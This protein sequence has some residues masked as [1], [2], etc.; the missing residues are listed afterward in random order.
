M[1]SMHLFID[2]NPNCSPEERVFSAHGKIKL[3]SQV[4]LDRAPWGVAWF[5]VVGMDDTGKI[6]P[7]QAQLVDDS[8]DGTAWLVTGGPW[9]LRL[10]KEG[11]TDK[12]DLKNSNQWGVPFLVLDRFG[13]DM[14]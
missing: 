3:I 12:W 13:T 6:T 11:S 7:V 8:A 2:E 14:R 5:D 10:R 9:G 1:R 4:Q